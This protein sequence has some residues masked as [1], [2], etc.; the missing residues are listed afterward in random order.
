MLDYADYIKIFI[1]LLAIVNPFGAI[2]LFISITA[3]QNEKQHKQTINLVAISV[4]IILLVTL[5]FGELLLRFFGIT[6][7]SFRVGGGI[8]I[9]LMAISMLHAKTSLLKQTNAEANESAQKESVAIVPLAIPL[10]AGPGAISA[11]ILAANK[12]H[13]VSHYFT[14]AAGILLLSLIVWILLHLSPWISKRLG[15]TGINVF[16]RIMGLILA[17]IAIEFIANGLKGI[18]PILA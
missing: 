12:S 5:F 8:L 11:V 16:T 3:D 10:L 4:A 13:A 17:A 1:G 18:F 9:L 14:I 6:I 15:I 7:D 2:P